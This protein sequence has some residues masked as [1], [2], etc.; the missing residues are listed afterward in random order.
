VSKQHQGS[1]RD[2]LKASVATAGTLGLAGAGACSDST[3][4]GPVRT[5]NQPENPPQARAGT[6][7]KYNSV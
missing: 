3:T 7:R 6:N 1:R 2:F 4:A 5:E